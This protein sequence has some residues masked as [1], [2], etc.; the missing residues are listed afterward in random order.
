MCISAQYNLDR[1]VNSNRSKIGLAGNQLAIHGTIDPKCQGPTTSCRSKHWL[2]TMHSTR[3]KNQQSAVRPRAY[4]DERSIA[5]R[6][7]RWRMFSSR[8]DTQRSAISCGVPIIVVQVQNA[9]V[10]VIC[11]KIM[12]CGPEWSFKHRTL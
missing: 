9:S 3:I 10:S 5:Q 4:V 11:E 6:F 12:S 2:Y 8:V 1:Y 7:K